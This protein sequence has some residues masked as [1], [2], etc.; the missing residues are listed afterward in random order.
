MTQHEHLTPP[1]P[2]PDDRDRSPRDLPRAQGQRLRTD[3]GTPRNAESVT[4]SSSGFPGSHAIG[5]PR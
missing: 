4:G 1:K 3:G 5:A 2:T